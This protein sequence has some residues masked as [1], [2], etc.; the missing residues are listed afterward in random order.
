MGILNF[1]VFGLGFGELALLS[2]FLLPF[3]LTLYCVI[4]IIRSEFKDGNTKLLFLIVVLLAPLL[5]SI[6]YLV[7]KKNYIVQKVTF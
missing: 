6:I 1:I 4:D 7:L 3:L 5:G 2:I